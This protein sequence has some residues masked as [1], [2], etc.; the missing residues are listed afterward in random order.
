[1]GFL[2]FVFL[3]FLL[4]VC[5]GGS[6][7]LDKGGPGHPDPEI[8]RGGKNFFRLFGLQIRRGPVSPGPSPGS[9]TGVGSLLVNSFSTLI[10][11]VYHVQNVSGKILLESKWNRFIWVVPAEKFFWSSGTTEKFCFS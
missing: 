4:L 11:V 5:S 9:S 8:S 6:R 1:M 10:L 2:N 7:P 3:S